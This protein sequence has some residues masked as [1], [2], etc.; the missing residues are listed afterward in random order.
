VA[1]ATPPAPE[2]PSIDGPWHG[3]LVGKL[4]LA[5]SLT[6]QGNAYAAV[7]DSLD[8]G[9]K[10]PV[11]HVALEG[12]KL[13]FAIAAVD[14]SYEGTVEGD[15][16]QGTWTQHGSAK[17]LEFDRGEPPADWT[18]A[19][20]PKPPLDAY[21]DV[22]VPEAPSPLRADGKTVLVYELHLTSYAPAELVSVDVTAG[23]H[24]L[25]H[26]A[27]SELAKAFAHPRLGSAAEEAGVNLAPDGLS[28]VYMWVTLDSTK[29]P[30]ALDHRIVVKQQGLE[31]TIP[32]VRVAVRDRAPRV[33]SP[34]LHGTGWMASN[35]PSNKSHHRRVI[36][37]LGGHA[38]VPQRFAI[39]WVRLGAD[40]KTTFT[41]DPSKN[42]SYLAYGG[43]ALAVGDGVVTEVKDGIQENVPQEPPAVPI[44]LETVAG[45]H[46][47]VDLGGG[48]FGLWAH[49]QPGSVRVKV[50]DHVRRGQVLG[51]VG[52]SGNST[53]PH[54]HFHVTDASSCLASE[55]IPYAFGSFEVR[56]PANAGRHDRELPTEDE[57]VSFP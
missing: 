4:H 26:L 46:V 56:G 37:P 9:A 52:N 47:I 11:D 2:G 38:R 48:Y 23:G 27:G 15:T 19:S 32:D 7:L 13:R 22:R 30:A 24:P 40:G 21:V 12:G 51:L 10:L 28:V 41:G 3:V 55:G 6:R 18:K 44:T 5:L 57:V 49:L 29:V 42:A 20:A 17:A 25:A 34:P 45:N 16:I 1:S 53:E 8:Q 31:L 50:G 43:E 35:G 33:F 54:L 36:L 39:D 14:G